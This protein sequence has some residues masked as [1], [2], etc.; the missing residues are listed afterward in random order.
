MLS[1]L[2]AA[3]VERIRASVPSLALVA[4]YTGQFA[5]GTRTPIRAPAV[6]VAVLG[7]RPASPADVGDGRMDATARLAAYCI[8]RYADDSAKREG[9]CMDLACSVALAVRLSNFGLPDTGCARVVEMQALTNAE[10]DHAGFSI[11]AVIWEQDIRLGA[12]QVESFG[13]IA[14]VHVGLA[15]HVGAGNAQAYTRIA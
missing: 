4:P 2:Q 7:V 6:L 10:S 5:L 14:E 12:A 8:A 9:A 1:A 13:P 11:W 3:A 15:P